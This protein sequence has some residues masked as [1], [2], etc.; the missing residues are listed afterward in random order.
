MDVG[1]GSSNVILLGDGKAIVLDCP[2]GPH[3]S[4]LP[5]MRLLQ[6]YGVSFIEVLAV[7]HGHAD[8]DAGA[9]DILVKYRGSIG[10]VYL[11]QDQPARNMR[12][13]RA[14]RQEVESEHI[15]EH[16]IHNLQVDVGGRPKLLWQDKERDLRLVLLYP[17]FFR[18]MAAQLRDDRNAT[19]AVL[20]L[21]TPRSRIL[22]AGDCTSD[23]WHAIHR[24]YKNER[25]KCTVMVIPHHGGLLSDDNETDLARTFQWL[26]GRCVD[27]EVGI[28]SVG[29]FNPHGHP[30]E[31]AI[32]AMHDSGTQVVCTQVTEKCCEQVE[33][34]RPGVLRPSRFCLSSFGSPRT[35]SGAPKN[36]ACA[37][38][39]VIE[40]GTTGCVIPQLVAH[41]RALAENPLLRRRLCR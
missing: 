33:H 7:S 13:L 21:V 41:Q 1:Q 38:S 30:R 4:S 37:G 31:A 20:C 27:A 19:S 6:H 40:V 11:L 29:T 24:W 17:N 26:Y 25:F 15:R 32:R 34:L 28:V 18:N 12:F 22:Y 16:Q 23:G 3:T 2:Q 10:H 14:L 9:T 5:T 36:I 35:G 39:V 8:H